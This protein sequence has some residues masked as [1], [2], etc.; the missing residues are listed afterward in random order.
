MAEVALAALAAEA[1]EAID[2]EDFDRAARACLRALRRFPRWVEGYWLLG[3]VL[4]EREYAAEAR[5]CFEA[6]A[7]AQPDDPRA[8]EGLAAVAEQRR[9]FATAIAGLARAV[10]VGETS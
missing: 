10:E 1:R 2:N 9:D 6:V 7:S 8:Y 3:Q 4:I 5:A